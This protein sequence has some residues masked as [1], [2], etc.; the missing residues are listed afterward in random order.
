MVEICECPATDVR[1]RNPYDHRW[2]PTES[3]HLLRTSTVVLVSHID[4]VMIG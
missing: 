1:G 4:H 3:I 2:T